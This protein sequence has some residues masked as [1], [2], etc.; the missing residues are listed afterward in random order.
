MTTF[1]LL[2]VSFALVT[3]AACSQPEPVATAPR[4]VLAQIVQP[5][6]NSLGNVYSGEVRARHE[7]DLAF[8]VG[9]K[10][11]ARQVDVGS[12]VV[13]GD[14]L[15]RLDPQDAK[16]AVEAA[17][18]QLAAAQADHSLAKAE[19]ERYRQLFAKSFVSQAVLD[20]RVT[21]FNATK[22]KLDQARAQHAAARNQ[23]DYTMLAANAD[24]V[25]TAVTAEP[26][27]VV[28]AGQPV[29]RLAR[30]DEKD[31]VINVPESRLAELREAKRVLVALWTHPE[32][33]Y[34]GHVREI[35][36]TADAVTR[37]FTVK[38]SVPQ[39]DTAV[40][41]GMTANVVVDNPSEASVVTLPL[42]AL[43]QSAGTASVWV[44]DPRTRKAA[45]RP[46]EIGAYRE[47]G[48]TVH[49]GIVAGD[50]VVTAGVH[51]LVIGETVRLAP[52]VERAMRLVARN[53]DSI[54]SNGG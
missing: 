3:L 36:P 19:L 27:Q 23:S 35:A 9:G 31:V 10:L 30:P 43:D 25:I 13:R 45:P 8:R 18:S 14:V 28:A 37:T 21:T 49:S 5:A 12:R 34:A 20:A 32:R 33:P 29:V 22:A 48:V 47:D 39:A 24:G 41:L 7:T 6:S 40:R 50:V 52:E 42:S 17:R 15:A 46:V 16:L 26:G 38:I 51:K 54:P 11:V 1:R 53:I 4:P 44:V 2:I